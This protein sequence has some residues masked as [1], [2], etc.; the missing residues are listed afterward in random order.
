MM[1]FFDLDGTLMPLP[2]V[3]RRLIARLVSDRQLS[4]WRLSQCALNI[5]FQKLK[6]DRWAQQRNKDYLAGLTVAEVEEAAR[7]LALDLAGLLRPAV[8]GQLQ[9]HVQRGHG[10]V[11][12]T[13]AIEALARPVA[14]AIGGRCTV[15]A[16][17]CASHGGRF[18]ARP[19]QRH[20]FGTGK[21]SLAR[22]IAERH[23]LALRDCW[24]Y[25]DSHHDLALLGAVGHPVAV[26][27]DRMLRRHAERCGWP[28]IDDGKRP[29]F[30]APLPVQRV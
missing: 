15:C 13:G 8:M 1:A 9:A 7:A 2:S 16:T 3:E 24:A 4:L 14:E 23:G 25:G 18:V 30:G 17:H 11:L 28:I 22:D 27:P 6:G 26:Y 21:A 12:L 29:A 20:P 5:G 19:P 10:I